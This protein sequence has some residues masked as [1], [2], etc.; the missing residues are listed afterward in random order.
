MKT[1][2]QAYSDRVALACA[3]FDDAL[4]PAGIHRLTALVL[5]AAA[6][7]A[8]WMTHRRGYHFE[9]MGLSRRDVACDVVAELLAEHEGRALGRFRMALARFEYVTR[10]A[11]AFDA[12]LMQIL[13]VT[14]DQNLTRIFREFDPV[15]ARALRMLRLHVREHDGEL[16]IDRDLA[17]TLYAPADARDD[18]HLE[19]ATLDELRSML[20]IREMNGNPAIS[21]LTACL[22]ALGRQAT[23]RCAVHEADVMRLTI[24][25]I[26]RTFDPE[27]FV[28]PVDDVSHD[29]RLFFT[30][31]EHALER[32]RAWLEAS[33][34]SRHKLTLTEC[35]ALLSALRAYV[36]DLANNDEQARYSYLR[37]VM[38]E[39]TYD[40]YRATYRNMFDYVVRTFFTNARDLLLSSGYTTGLNEEY[41]G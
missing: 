29:R 3:L 16:R 28:E 8:G 5:D 41:G 30:E 34:V 19:L 24:D 1:W 11:A 38:P 14:I 17:G 10:D 37:A 20:Y 4:A 26:G 21:V 32:T 18:R 33:Y 31:I 36:H 23:F 2:L 27:Q 6:H 22:E 35:E 12:A 7:V 9:K 40:R 25:H 13:T 39:L 15:Y